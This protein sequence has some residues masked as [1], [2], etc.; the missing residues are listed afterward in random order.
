MLAMEPSSSRRWGV[1]VCCFDPRCSL[2]ALF[3]GGRS[4]WLPLLS[5]PTWPLSVHHRPPT[6][7]LQEVLADVGEGLAGK[8]CLVSG[9]G[10]VRRPAVCRQGHG[11]AA[12]GWLL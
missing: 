10:C 11:L 2:S 5:W 7:T 3:C 1:G 12:T 9:S 6:A 8:R 4:S